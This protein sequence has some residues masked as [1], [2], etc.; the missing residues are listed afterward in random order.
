[1]RNRC[2]LSVSLSLLYPALIVV[3]AVQISSVED[4]ETMS[5]ATT[6]D[7]NYL[8]EIEEEHAPDLA[9]DGRSFADPVGVSNI[10]N[11]LGVGTSASAA[12]SIVHSLDVATESGIGMSATDMLP[13]ER[14]VAPEANF[15]R[16]VFSAN[17]F[18]SKSTRA[19]SSL[20]S[21]D[22][23]VLRRLA[24]L[25][26]IELED[27]IT[28]PNAR[29]VLVRHIINSD[30]FTQSRKHRKG[31]MHAHSMP[32][33]T[34]LCVNMS[35][36]FTSHAEMTNYFVDIVLS[37]A[38]DSKL[39]PT[40]KLFVIA[41][42]LHSNHSG[43]LAGDL[44]VLQKRRTSLRIL[45]KFRKSENL[46]DEECETLTG[47]GSGFETLHKPEL[48]SIA[49]SHGIS[50]DSRKVSK[51]ELKQLIVDHLVRG[52]CLQDIRVQSHA[53]TV[54][55][56]GSSCSQLI[57]E[58]LASQTTPS[59]DPVVFRMHSIMKATVHCSKKT[60]L[61]FFS[62]LG[63]V[64]SAQDSIRQLRHTLKRFVVKAQA[65]KDSRATPSPR[66]CRSRHTGPSH[67]A[68]RM[69]AIGIRTTQAEDCFFV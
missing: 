67:N 66:Q 65:G 53:G 58:Y 29:M 19:L 60:L 47:P 16:D 17:F 51:E 33:D 14:D 10:Y 13:L 24:V 6:L 38:N 28:V 32:T 43:V 52:R 42:A 37:H 23:Q 56:R 49:H 31:K 8:A 41:Q 61:R 35:L 68:G 20:F 26:S 5:N 12:R 27:D 62:Q 9:L 59:F 2:T 40:D 69:A 15:A 63:L 18:G 7:M 39:L 36:Q 34:S 57:S 4:A 45:N 48:V 55:T 21:S 3:S 11:D 1:M 44:S 54:E 25:H 50:V 46:T 30:C 22:I 64:Y